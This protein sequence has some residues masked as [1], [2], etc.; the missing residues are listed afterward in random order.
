M[1]K[2]ESGVDLSYIIAPYIKLEPLKKLVESCTDTENLH[3]I[4]NWQEQSIVSG[5][6]DIEIYPYLE[7]LK[8]PLYS[9]KTIHLK[10]FIFKDGTVF[11]TS[12]NVSRRG[13]GLGSDNENNIEVGCFLE[14]NPNDFIEIEKIILSSKRITPEDYQLA[15]SYVEE[16]K[17]PA[18][19]LP[20]LELT[21]TGQ[22]FSLSL[23]PE[24]NNPQ[25]L[26]EKYANGDFDL[27]AGHDLATYEI[28][29]RLGLPPKN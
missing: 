3:V 26:Y 12:G 28:P 27:A 21:P 22:D 2:I 23:F 8:V 17:K 5:S 9:N 4:S 13:L 6:T 19:P 1:Q 18:E 16:H 20:D 15:L 25:E 7:D 14:L 24:M 11:H 29:S 10:L